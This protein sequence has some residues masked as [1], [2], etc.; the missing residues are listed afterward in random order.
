MRLP[1]R[2]TPAADPGSFR[3]AAGVDAPH[4]AGIGASDFPPAAPPPS[5]AAISRLSASRSQPPPQPS[6]AFEQLEAPPSPSKH[7]RIAAPARTN[8]RAAVKRRAAI[9]QHAC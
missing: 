8:S 6:A 5:P 3:V 4:A 2:L 9:T 1:S 7:A